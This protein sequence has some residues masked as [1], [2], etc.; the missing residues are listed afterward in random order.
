MDPMDQFENYLHDN[1]NFSWDEIDDLVDT[2][3]EMIEDKLKLGVRFANIAA[4]LDD[5]CLR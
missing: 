4:S 5:S 3:K 1:S 2:N